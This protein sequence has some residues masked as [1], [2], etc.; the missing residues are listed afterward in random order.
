MRVN[1][2]ARV[3]EHQYRV[4]DQPVQHRRV[5][6]WPRSRRSPRRRSEV[7]YRRPL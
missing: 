6:T 2:I 7:R 4:L 5:S 3:L 1:V